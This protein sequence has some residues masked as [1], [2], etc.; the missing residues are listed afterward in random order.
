MVLLL[1]PCPVES[2][3]DVFDGWMASLLPAMPCVALT[4]AMKK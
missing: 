3:W 1:L 4:F 2:I